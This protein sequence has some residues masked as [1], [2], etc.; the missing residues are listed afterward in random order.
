MIDTDFDVSDQANPI[1]YSI[2]LDNEIMFDTAGIYY[3]GFS[4]T[5][6]TVVDS[7]NNLIQFYKINKVN[8]GYQYISTPY[9][10]SWHM[11]ID[12]M[13]NNW[14]FYTEYQPKI[15][16]QTL[17]VGDALPAGTTMQNCYWYV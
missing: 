11:M 9:L 16:S 6:N 13:S 8:E 5:H 17:A 14:Y 7:S 12:D 15:E 3:F 1:Q 2:N 10:M 4:L